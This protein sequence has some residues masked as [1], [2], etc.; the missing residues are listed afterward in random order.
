M[1]QAFRSRCALFRC[2]ASPVI[3]L[4]HIYRCLTLAEKLHDAGWRVQ[5]AINEAA[6]DLI[7]IP[8]SDLLVITNDLS[9]ADEAKYFSS[10]GICVDLLIIDHYQRSESFERCAKQWVNQIFV[11]DDLCDR[12]HLCDFLLDQ[13]VGRDNNAYKHL[14]PPDCV[15]F[16]GPDFALLRT[17]FI[18][19]RFFPP[20]SSVE[21]KS[22]HIVVSLGGTAS[23]Q[24]TDR[25]VKAIVSSNI[26]TTIDVVAGA[27]E[28]LSTPETSDIKLH[29]NVSDM[30][31]LLV[32]ADL[33]IGAAGGTALERCC[34]GLPSLLIATAP[35]Q[36]SNIT[37]LVNAGA[38]IYLGAEATISEET[39]VKVLSAIVQD[40]KKL[41]HMARSSAAVC[42]GLGAWRI[43]EKLCPSKNFH[44]EAVSLLRAT[45]HHCDVMFQWQNE[46]NARRFSRNEKA[47]S[48]EEHIDWLNK[49][50]SSTASDLSII[51]LNGEP[52]GVIRV[53]ADVMQGRLEVSIL[54][55]SHYRSKGVGKAALMVLINRFGWA[56]LYAE[57][58]P[59]NKASISVFK[60]CGFIQTSENEYTRQPARV[61]CYSQ[62]LDSH[63]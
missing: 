17:Q 19:A 12:K 1:P 20:D 52:C 32:N 60:Q 2:D 13:T 39:I 50:L 10:L 48:Y 54:L 43:L 51:M 11:I 14:V 58:H 42:D 5:F 8:Y 62:R 63:P 15:S 57:I 56:R 25:V 3:G 41:R 9:E 36:S 21:N 33:A 18:K 27:S 31:S 59:D 61:G 44:D 29:R 6:V 26:V 34:M 16:I 23:R 30:A 47:P 40:K 35:N 22:F 38:G 49:V 45:V 46:L 28:G 7:K 37:G 53:D 24:L 4:G 55:S